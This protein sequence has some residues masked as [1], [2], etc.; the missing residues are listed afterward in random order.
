MQTNEFNGT[1]SI[2]DNEYGIGWFLIGNYT[3]E[4]KANN[5]YQEQYDILKLKD[6]THAPYLVNYETSAV[7]S[8][9]GMVM[10]SAQILV[11]SFNE[12]YDENI[13]NAITYVN[14]FTYKTGDTYGNLIST[15]KYTGKVDGNVGMNA[16][17]GNNGELQYDENG[18]LIL[19]SDNAIPVL[20]IEN[21]FKIDDAYSINITIDGDYMQKPSNVSW[22]N[23]PATILALSDSINR[24]LSW[25]GVYKGYLQ[26]YAFYDGNPIENLTAEATRKGF[27]SISLEKYMG[28]KINIQVV[29]TRNENVD[30]YIN[31]EKIKT[32][33]AGTK[34]LTFEYTTLGDLRVG[35]G[36]KYFGKIYEFGIYGI[37]INEAGIQNNWERAKQYVEN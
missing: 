10:Y 6:T 15:S 19:D 37:A 33:E 20:E 13:Q 11:H 26:V 9:D 34:K 5:T 30:I 14:S 23:Y 3:E 28:K 25:I 1:I 32:F 17:K 29:A 18:A 21:K 24:Y 12:N 35:R 31:G 8:I 27:A 36:L 2:G 22:A 4:E 7:L 16:Y